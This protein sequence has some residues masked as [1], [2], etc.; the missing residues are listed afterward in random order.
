MFYSFKVRGI[1]HL[2]GTLKV[3][4]ALERNSDKPHVT[5]IDE[6]VSIID[7]KTDKDVLPTNDKNNFISKESPRNKPSPNAKPK[8]LSGMKVCSNDKICILYH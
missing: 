5:I 3:S 7:Q 4:F 6:C 8:Y 1:A 2:I